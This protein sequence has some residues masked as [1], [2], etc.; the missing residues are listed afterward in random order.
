MADP[1]MPKNYRPFAEDTVAQM[2]EESKPKMQMTMAEG[3]TTTLKKKT[4][5]KQGE[6]QGLRPADSEK[7]MKEPT[8]FGD[9]GETP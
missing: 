1:K 5:R 3:V 8:P 4:L 9:M 6:G 7:G 2:E